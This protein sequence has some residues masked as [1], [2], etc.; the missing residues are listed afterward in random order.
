[1]PD[2]QSVKGIVCGGGKLLR[3]VAGEHLTD[4]VSLICPTLNCQADI[5]TFWMNTGQEWR[6]AR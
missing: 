4:A 6:L 5:E 1:M 2:P 3:A